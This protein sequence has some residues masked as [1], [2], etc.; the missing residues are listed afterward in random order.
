MMADKKIQIEILGSVY[1]SKVKL[2]GIVSMDFTEATRLVDLKVARFV[3]AP[4]G[5]KI[6]DGIAE[7][8]PDMGWKKEEICSFLEEKKIPFEDK[9]TKEVLVKTYEDWKATQK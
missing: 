9:S 7:E 3:D 2:T 5:A 1:D 4:A 8:E 6:S